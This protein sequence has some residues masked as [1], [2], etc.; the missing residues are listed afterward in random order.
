MAHSLGL[1]VVAEG[2]ESEDQAHFLRSQGCD[3]L[4]GFLYSEPL[5]AEAIPALFEEKD[6][7]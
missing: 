6:P 3:M 1:R 2:V 7:E 5:P 4:Q